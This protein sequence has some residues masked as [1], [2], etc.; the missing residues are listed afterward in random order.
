MVANQV[1]MIFRARQF[2]HKG[3]LYQKVKIIVHFSKVYF[4]GKIKKK[5][6]L[7]NKTSV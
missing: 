6:N 4:S 3:F 7:K 1:D 5:M 2:N